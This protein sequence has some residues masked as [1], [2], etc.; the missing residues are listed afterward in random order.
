LNQ[1]QPPQEIDLFG[2]GDQGYRRPIDYV[3]LSIGG[4]D[5]GFASL[6]AQEALPTETI[7]LD[8]L[9][10]LLQHAL[11][12]IEDRKGAEARLSFLDHIYTRLDDAFRT[13][14]PVREHDLS[15]ILL[16]AYPLPDG[17]E[18]TSLCGEQ[19]DGAPGRRNHGR[20]KRL[21]RIHEWRRA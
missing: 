15:R 9:R 10:G 6:V 7:D 16:T 13:L 12:V 21:G 4:N 18:G 2:C 5:I 20:H 1:N 19:T 17:W 3:L 14:M 8:V 11:G